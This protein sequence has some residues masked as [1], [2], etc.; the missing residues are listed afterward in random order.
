M[1]GISA[2]ALA[3]SLLLAAPAAAESEP[4]SPG[5]DLPSS[6]EELEAALDQVASALRRVIEAVPRFE[7]PE[8]TEEGDIVIRRKRPDAE[9]LPAPPRPLP[10]DS[11]RI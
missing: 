10:E 5:R 8:I 1:K 2:I 11:A 3:L 9:P 7:P 4:R 6:I